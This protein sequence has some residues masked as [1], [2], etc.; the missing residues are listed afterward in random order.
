MR[1]L[2]NGVLLSMALVAPVV[3]APLSFAVNDP[4][5]KYLVEVLFPEPPQDPHQLAQALITLR[6]K[7]TLETLQQWQT[8]AGNV[9]A[10]HNDKADAWLL[11]PYGLLYFA[12]F[13]FD[14][15]QDLAIRN[16]TDPKV[17]GQSHFD[18]YLQDPQQTRW[19][20]NAALTDLAK[21]SNGM[22]SV[23]PTDGIL[24]SQT[25]R[26]CCWM[27]TSQWKMRDGELVRLRSYTQEEVP[28]TEFGENSSMPRGYMLRT[29]GDWKDGQWHE[30]P[31]L[32]GPVIEDSQSLVGTL[33]GKIPVEI[34]Y[35][36]QGEVLIGEVRYTKGGSGEPIKLVGSRE[37]Y[38]DDNFVYLHEY[39]DDGRQTGIWRITR[40]TIEPH[41]YTGT[42]VSGAKGDAR[43]LAILLHDEYR[44]PDYD[45]LN[46][47]DR[48]QRSGHYQMRR[49][50]L[51]RD[52]DLDLKILPDRD[53]EGREVA[54]FTVT[55]KDAV[56][57]KDIVTEHHIVPMETENLIIVR[58]P[59]A[60]KIN[61]PYHI[62]L[63]KNFAVI[64]Y[65]AA[66]DSQE[67]LTGM[68]RKRP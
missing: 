60:S 3:A 34:W 65:N 12:D 45:K 52:G 37:A 46:E 6:D 27:R 63:V 44:E 57:L 18:V 22:F 40:Q 9:P 68:Y 35:Q 16:G 15:R 56:T 23:S 39:A 13:N 4:S 17:D 20:L 42:W 36:D 24:H 28:P 66:P 67:M 14:G 10:N 32:E 53:A 33:N 55:L 58:E 50:F 43:E 7:N 30:Q 5:G 61:G 49:D 47:V 31:S 51:G 59:Q 41:N 1:S 25:D 21:E 11:G 8:Q 64:N 26:G 48:D 54:E 38:G 19:V 29:T 62:Q 2:V